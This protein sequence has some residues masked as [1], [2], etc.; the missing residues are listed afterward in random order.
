RIAYLAPLRAEA[1]RVYQSRGTAPRLVSRRGENVIDVLLAAERAETEALSAVADALVRLG[2]AEAFDLRPLDPERRYYE[3]RLII[4]GQEVALADVGSGVAQ[5]LPVVTLLFT[6]PEGMILLLEHP[7]LHLHPSAQAAL[8]DIMLEAAERRKLQLIVESHSEHLLTRLQRRIAEREPAFAT[9]QNV[10]AYFCQPSPEGSRI[11]AVEVNEYGQI[12]NYPPN[13][14]GDLAGDLTAATR[15]GLR[16]RREE[17]E[18][19][20]RRRSDDG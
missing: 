10:R 20:G 9:P 15:A 16:R 14:F 18:G 1:K 13:F 17:L 2:L 7:D 3:P 4:N 8:A 11:Q 12:L 5:V 19:A 6:A